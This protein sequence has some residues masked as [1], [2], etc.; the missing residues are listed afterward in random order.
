MARDL[1]RC[2]SGMDH[3]PMTYYELQTE[4]DESGAASPQETCLPEKLVHTA[5]GTILSLSE[6][7][8]PDAS[9]RHVLM[10][11][12]IWEAGEAGM[13]IGEL[14]VRMEKALG[15]H[16]QSTTSRFARIARELGLVE[17]FLKLGDGR[18]RLLRL[19]RVGRAVLRAAQCA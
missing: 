10:L 7:L 6:A 19:T 13:T 3:G 1:R 15:S 8:G 18:A 5:R 17:H 11:L 2:R 14:E 16:A 12:L 4:K 9:L